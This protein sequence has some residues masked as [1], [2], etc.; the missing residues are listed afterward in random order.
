[1]MLEKLW[2]SAVHYHHHP[3]TILY[4]ATFR[5]RLQF[6]NTQAASQWVQLCLT[7]DANVSSLVA[8][9]RRHIIFTWC[10]LHATTGF[11]WEEFFVPVK[12]KISSADEKISSETLVRNSI[13]YSELILWG[14]KR[15]TNCL[16][17]DLRR[18]KIKFHYIILLLLYI[19]YA[20]LYVQA[21]IFN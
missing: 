17:D 6:E 20:Y 7:H 12:R 3:V 11:H 15:I 19:I 14:K 5:M 8:L 21:H 16:R 2:R 18:L 1:M 4:R 13:L 9:L 10:Y